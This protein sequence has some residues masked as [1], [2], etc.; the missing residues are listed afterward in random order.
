MMLFAV[1]FL[2]FLVGF[3]SLCAWIDTRKDDYSIPAAI[4]I[5][6][7]LAGMYNVSYS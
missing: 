5:V 2:L 4:G 7:G 6:I 3:Y 1:Y